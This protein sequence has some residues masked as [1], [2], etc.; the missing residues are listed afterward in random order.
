MEPT[1]TESGV[2]DARTDEDPSTERDTSGA[3]SDARESIV[4][5]EVPSLDPERSGVS[6]DVADSG[7]MGSQTSAGR[8]SRDSRI[9]GQDRVSDLEVRLADRESELE[10]ARVRLEEARADLDRVQKERDELRSRVS[11]LEA[12]LKELRAAVDAGGVEST[13]EDTPG[14]TTANRGDS[15]SL[16]PAQAM[17]ETNLFVRYRSK[18]KTT[19]DDVHDGA[20]PDALADNLRL[21]HHTE[22]EDEG[23]TVEGEPFEAWL[24]NTVQ[25]RF[26]R[27]LT[28]ILPFEIRDTGATNGLAALYTALPKIDRVELAGNIEVDTTDGPREVEFDVVVRDRMGEPLA[29]ARFDNS[30]EPVTETQLADLLKST[31]DVAERIETLASAF[32]VAKSYFD[33][34]ALDTAREATSGSLLS[35]DKRRSFVKLSR[36]Q[37]YH[38]CLVEARGGDF[39][40]SVPD[41]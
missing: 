39:H 7:I 37:G 11:E 2:T 9:E 35:R 36:N 8:T 20:D 31:T 32:F 3:A 17:S 10:D 13:S 4:N 21:E 30:R 1:E 25:F 6:D 14:A 15:K 40:L 23:A 5:R 16:S 29:V 18:G 27:W 12:E 24:H 22:F 26:L 34:D 33:P 41:L 38:L 19:L 28:T